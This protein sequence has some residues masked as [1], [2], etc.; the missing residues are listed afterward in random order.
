MG[1]IEKIFGHIKKNMGY[2]QVLVRGIKKVQ[3]VWNMLCMTYN[4]KRMYNLQFH[5]KTEALC[6]S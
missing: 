3:L 4:L 6:M 5:N 1:A 2:K